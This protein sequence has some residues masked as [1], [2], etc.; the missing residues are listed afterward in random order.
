MELFNATMHD[1]GKQDFGS[2]GF[3]FA[4]G[5]TSGHGLSVAVNE[6]FASIKERANA[7]IAQ[8]VEAGAD[9]VLVGGLGSVTIALWQAANDAGLA[10]FEAATERKRDENDRFVFV[11]SGLRRLN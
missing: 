2:F 6:D 1:Q 3:T 11:L 7:V 4:G 8:A 9:G 5:D 10:V